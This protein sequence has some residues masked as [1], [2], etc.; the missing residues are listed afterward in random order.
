M[1]LFNDELSNWMVS[2]GK[3]GSLELPELSGNVGDW[4]E[5]ELPESWGILL[6][7]SSFSSSLFFLLWLLPSVPSAPPF[8]MLL[9]TSGRGS[10]PTRLK[11]SW[12]HKSEI[13]H[14]NIMF[15]CSNMMFL[16]QAIKP[17]WL[18]KKIP[19]TVWNLKNR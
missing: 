8:G 11:C 1:R 12:K 17:V 9:T 5:D 16:Y 13:H 7:R 6:L 18:E 10:T 15:W 19:S 2:V 3:G 4:S 14:K